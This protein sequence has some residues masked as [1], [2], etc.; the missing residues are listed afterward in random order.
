MMHPFYFY[1]YASTFLEKLDKL[2]R[3]LGQTDLMSLLLIFINVLILTT[4][5]ILFS[6]DEF[7]LLLCINYKFIVPGSRF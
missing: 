1:M 2:I 4:R 3:V 7:I 6:T 5:K